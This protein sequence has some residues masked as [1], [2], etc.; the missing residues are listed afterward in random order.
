MTSKQ[1]T[2][3][4]QPL[5]VN[6][7][8]SKIATGKSVVLRGIFEGKMQRNLLIY[9]I[10]AGDG[11]MLAVIKETVKFRTEE[12]ADDFQAVR[13]M[14]ATGGTEMGQF[15]RLMTGLMHSVQ[16]KNIKIKS[17][18]E[19]V[20]RIKEVFTFIQPYND[21]GMRTLT[22]ASPIM[23]APNL[24]AK[25]GYPF[26]DQVKLDVLEEINEELMYLFKEFNRETM[27]NNQI[28]MWDLNHADHTTIKIKNKTEVIELVDMENKV[29]NYY[30]YPAAIAL[31]FSIIQE[32]FNAGY[33]SA[34]DNDQWAMC[35]FSWTNRGGDK[36]LKFFVSPHKWKYGITCKIYSDDTHIA[37]VDENGEMRIICA[38]VKYLD[39]SLSSKNIALV[40]NFFLQ[41]LVDKNGEVIYDGMFEN[42][43]KYNCIKAFISMVEFPHGL[44]ATKL[45]ALN[46]GIPGTTNIATVCTINPMIEMAVE[47]KEKYPDG[48]YPH[49]E[50]EKLL[51]KK[52]AEYG[53]QIKPGTEK[54]YEFVY[55]APVG[56]RTEFKILGQYLLRVEFGGEKIWVNQPERVSVLSTLLLPTKVI[57]RVKNTI[58]EK[59]NNLIWQKRVYGC[60]RALGAMVSG[61]YLYDDYYQVAKAFW[62]H[63]KKLDTVITIDDMI[64]INVA[65][66]CEVTD[67]LSELKE[68]VFPTKEWFYKIYTSIDK[69]VIQPIMQNKHT[70]AIVQKPQMKYATMDEIIEATKLRH[71][72]DV[73]EIVYVPQSKVT[74]DLTEQ[75]QVTPPKIKEP[76]TKLQKK[77]IRKLTRRQ[78]GTE[79]IL[80]YQNQFKV[81]G[82]PVPTTKRGK[83]QRSKKG[84]IEYELE[85][86]DAIIDENNDHEVIELEQ[87][88]FETLQRITEMENEEEIEWD[89]DLTEEEQQREFERLYKHSVAGIM[90]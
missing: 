66:G 47:L 40:T 85:E 56:T 62:D 2:D 27:T 65:I 79:R 76:L 11:E 46:S 9:D 78:L 4:L 89:D 28:L 51:V 81:L 48:R 29:R 68:G 23:Y 19:T 6:N 83:K 45:E 86:F 58:G 3:L 1:L 31:A 10:I 43:I 54:S 74:L 34:P 30:V 80:K 90:L 5:V 69:P 14:I 16:Y 32:L 87:K 88:Y 41:S 18:N 42:L 44:V 15:R 61:G 57:K 64:D 59:E 35:G 72:F 22:E 71:L 73:D 33:D 8:I 20:N 52:Y 67:F 55:D 37:F 7:L 84:T 36:L 49:K 53:M 63:M 12:I 60:Q 21:Q 50:V 25:A 24:K 77:N 38:D 82:Y 39:L 13:E 70:I 17:D 26:G 75:K